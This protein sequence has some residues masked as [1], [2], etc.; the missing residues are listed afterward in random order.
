MDPLRLPELVHHLIRPQPMQLIIHLGLTRHSQVIT[1]A[2]ESGRVSHFSST[3]WGRE[4]GR[5]A[6]CCVRTFFYI[7]KQVCQLSRYFR[8]C[9]SWNWSSGNG[10]RNSSAYFSLSLSL[11]LFNS[12]TLEHVLEGFLLLESAKGTTTIWLIVSQFIRRHQRHLKEQPKVHFK[13]LNCCLRR[14]KRVP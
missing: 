8:L 5:G 13:Q 7:H 14:Q 11:S 2:K 6:S 1:E 12:C 3:S 9:L 10:N 4:S